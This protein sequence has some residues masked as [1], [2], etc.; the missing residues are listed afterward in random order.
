MAIIIYLYSDHTFYE[1]FAYC[2]LTVKSGRG[3][4]VWQENITDRNK[5]FYFFLCKENLVKWDQLTSSIHTVEHKE[6]FFKDNFL[7]LGFLMANGCP[8][9][10]YSNIPKKSV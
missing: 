3:I 1:V 4:W 8:L 6:I 10:F 2:K 9:L 7:F 5:L